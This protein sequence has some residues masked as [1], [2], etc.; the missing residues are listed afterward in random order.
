[1]AKE[2]TMEKK[3][4]ANCPVCG[5]RLFTIHS[6]ALEVQCPNC[7]TDLYVKY[8]RDVLSVREAIDYGDTKGKDNSNQ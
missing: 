1:M 4:I 8:V 5:T 2:G 7:K 3:Y 6:G